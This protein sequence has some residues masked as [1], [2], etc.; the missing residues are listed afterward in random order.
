MTSARGVWVAQS[1]ERLTS[2]QVVIPQ[3]LSLSLR[4]P[5]GSLLLAQSLPVS[6]PLSTPPAHSAPPSLA[7]ACVLHCHKNK[8]FFFFFK[9][10]TEERLLNSTR[11][12]LLREDLWLL[13][14]I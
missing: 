1:A 7:R 12:K 14:L 10:S 6:D 13:Q 11:E 4:P 8:L 9:N 5:L 2:A 3:F